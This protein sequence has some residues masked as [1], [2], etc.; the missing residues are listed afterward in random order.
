MLVNFLDFFAKKKNETTL[1][2]M[3]LAMN[4]LLLTILAK[5][6]FIFLLTRQV[7]SY[8]AGRQGGGREENLN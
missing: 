7:E 3:F 4:S 1:P 2:G 5:F 8:L 6:E